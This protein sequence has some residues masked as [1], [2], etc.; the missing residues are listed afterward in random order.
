MT[1]RIDVTSDAFV[2]WSDIGGVVLVDSEG[3]ARVWLPDTKRFWS[4]SR[5]RYDIKRI[6]LGVVTIWPTFDAYIDGK[7]FL[8]LAVKHQCYT[9]VAR[10]GNW[11][12]V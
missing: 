4:W 5:R 2:D 8:E 7:P 12:I 1:N 3:P 11:W 9:L 10:G 6:G